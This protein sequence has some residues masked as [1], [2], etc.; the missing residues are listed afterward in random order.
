[1]AKGPKVKYDPIMCELV[2]LLMA[3]GK[4]KTAVAADLGISRE[5]L[6]RWCDSESPYYHEDFADAVSLGETLSQSWW[7]EQG[8]KGIWGGKEFNA[9]TWIY[10]MKNRFPRDWRDKPD[11]EQLTD[12]LIQII[13]SRQDGNSQI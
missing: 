6:Y 12:R 10:T 4:S 3:K 11:A 8:I 5:T 7:E 2:L 13:L 1:M 9:T